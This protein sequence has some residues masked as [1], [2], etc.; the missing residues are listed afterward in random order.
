MGSRCNMW[1]VASL[2]T[3]VREREADTCRD[4]SILTLGSVWLVLI[5][6]DFP[7]D[8]TGFPCVFFYMSL[9]RCIPTQTYRKYLA[10]L[11]E[12]PY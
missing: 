11:C 10:L 5:P 2:S 9:S 8:V 1:G 3:K 12:N 4:A 7:D 6:C